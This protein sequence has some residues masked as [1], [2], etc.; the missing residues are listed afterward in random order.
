MRVLITNNTLADRAGSEVYVR[1]LA[2]AL[3][4][5]GHNPVAYSTRL[6]RV[7]DELREATIPAI[8][9]LRLLTAVPDII[10]ASNHHGCPDPCC[11]SLIPGPVYFFLP[12]LAALGG[13][14]PHFP[15]Y[16][17]HVASTTSAGNGLQWRGTVCPR[18]AHRIVSQFC[19]SGAFCAAKRT[20]HDPSPCHWSSAIT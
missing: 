15:H 12:W 8:D 7:A 14:A 1:D 6:G 2:L 17:A 3:L 16:P 20:A 18:R 4:R 10:H 13:N 19:R 11:I 9:D 5:R